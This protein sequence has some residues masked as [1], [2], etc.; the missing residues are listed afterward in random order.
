MPKG[1]AEVIISFKAIV[2]S[3]S[4]VLGMVWAQVSDFAREEPKY[5]SRFGIQFCSLSFG[6]YLVMFN[7]SCSA[8]MTSYWFVI[9]EQFLIE[10]GK[11]WFSTVARTVNIGPLMS[12]TRF[13]STLTSTKSQIAHFQL[14]VIDHTMRTIN[15][16]AL[17]PLMNIKSWR[18]AQGVSNVPLTTSYRMLKPN[19]PYDTDWTWWKAHQLV[20]R[21]SS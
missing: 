12:M 5:K 9:G 3:P 2:G 1:T 13:R 11:L 14:L 4:D 15:I 20:S 17:M 18:T 6:R 19:A 16:R 10:S 7:D 21:I 8:K